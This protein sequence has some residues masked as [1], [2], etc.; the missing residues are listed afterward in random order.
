MAD[1]RALQQP[2]AL[3]AATAGFIAMWATIAAFP[4]LWIVIM[5]FKLPLDAFAEDPLQVVIGY[6]T[7]DERGG[8]SLI[9][10]VVGWRSFSPPKV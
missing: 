3:R 5:S 9:G 1:T 7:L 2:I 4:L 6:R 10:I 8:L